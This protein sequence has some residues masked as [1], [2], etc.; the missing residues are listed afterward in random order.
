M[1]LSNIIIVLSR[2]SEPG[3]TGAVCRVMK[4]L[5]LS[6]LRLAKPEFNFEKSD[7][8]IRARAVHAA[9]VWESAETFSSLS[10]AVADCAIVIGTTQRRGQRRKQTMTPGET[11]SFLKSH[12]GNAAIVF[13]NER[14]G[15][16]TEE[17]NLCNIASHIPANAS[18]PSLNLS[19]AVLVY[20]YELYKAFADQTSTAVKG[21]WVPLE[22]NEIKPVVKKLTDELKGLGFYKQGG[23]EDQE[24]FFTDVISRAGL[25]K[26][27][28]A[29][30]SLIVGKAGRLNLNVSDG[31]TD[32]GS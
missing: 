26:K 24:R 28:A 18:F 1:H 22:Q 23:R 30:F 15:L 27:E 12:S 14:T 13:G 11:V 16:D 17:L 20:A 19:H 3:N 8:V 32:D 9:D 25:T 21:K 6:R 4:N 2:P 5:R 7:T 10:E 31:R 29:Y